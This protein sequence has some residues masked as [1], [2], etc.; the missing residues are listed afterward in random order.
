MFRDELSQKLS[1]IFGFKKT[2]FN[3]PSVDAT[4]GSFEQ[5]VLFVE[6]DECKS[7][8]TQGTEIAKVTGS[9]IVFVQTNKMP[10]GYMSKRIQ[11]ADPELTKKLFFYDVDTNPN[12]SPSKIQNI[13]ERRAKFIYFHSAEYD[14]EHGE[15]TS[16]E[17][18]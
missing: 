1:A 15:L 14:P 8:I 18:I 5:E 11:Q 16:L 7:R 6:V 17:G 2:T 13:Q 4:T 12:N 10:F 9:L 3:A